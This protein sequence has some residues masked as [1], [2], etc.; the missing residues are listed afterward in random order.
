MGYTHYFHVNSASEGWAVIWPRLIADT[1]TIIAAAGVPL[2]GPPEYH[3]NGYEMTTPPIVSVDEGIDLNG[4]GKNGHEPLVIGVK[5]DGSFNFVKTARKPYDKVV[6][7]VLLR[8]AMLAPQAV[9]VSSDGYWDDDREWIAARV[10]YQRLWPQDEIHCPWKEED[11]HEVNVD[12]PGG[13]G[14]GCAQQ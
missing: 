12:N 5:E 1:Q 8:A 14:T 11:G 9:D 6:A 13:G 3:P 10:L 2:T 7:C 4:V